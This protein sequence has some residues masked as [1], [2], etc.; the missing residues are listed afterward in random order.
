MAKGEFIVIIFA[1]ETYA[2]TN[3]PAVVK[4]GDR[5]AD[6]RL[7]DLSLPLLPEDRLLATSCTTTP[8]SSMF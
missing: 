3:A 7:L 5:G 1:S 4:A 8:P 6:E 2:V